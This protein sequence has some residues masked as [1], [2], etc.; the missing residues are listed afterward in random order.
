M[1]IFW[2]PK[3]RIFKENKHLLETQYVPDSKMVV[4]HILSQF[5]FVPFF[6]FLG[7]H[8]WH[9]E[10]PRLGFESEMQP[11]AYTTATAMSYLS[12]ICDLH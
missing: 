5:F 3:N 8:V 10:V 9:M 11:M 4:L 2:G 7:L 1:M 6:V 12:H